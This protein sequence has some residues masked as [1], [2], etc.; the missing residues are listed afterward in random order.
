MCL[1]QRDSAPP[2][3][4]L[5]FL[6]SR[7]LAA[8]SIPSFFWTESGRRSVFRRTSSQPN[9]SVDCMKRHTELLTKEGLT[10]L[11]R[12]CLILSLSLHLLVSSSKALSTFVGQRHPCTLGEN[13][14]HNGRSRP[15]HYTR[16]RASCSSWRLPNNPVPSKP[17]V[18]VDHGIQGWDP[19]SL[20]RSLLYLSLPVPIESYSADMHAA[21][22]KV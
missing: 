20:H 18:P 8:G 9:K 22:D 7:V 4:F 16:T 3:A 13:G 10:T 11:P 5:P 6:S 14:R 15:V 1:K 12:F 19:S 2:S 17:S 21:A